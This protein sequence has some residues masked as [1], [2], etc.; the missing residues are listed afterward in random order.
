MVTCKEVSGL[1][2]VNLDSGSSATP[3]PSPATPSPPS[4]V[5]TPSSPGAT[6]SGCRCGVKKAQRIVGGTE[7][8]P[9]NKYPWMAAIMDGTGSSQFCGGTLVA[10]KYVIS[11]A[12]CMFYDQAGTQ[13]R[14]ANDVSVRIGEHDL[15][16]TGETTLPEKTIA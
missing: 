10:S 3:S 16:T 7:V 11:A 9:V 1:S 15:S 8:N 14:P 4:P 6:P 13:P 2:D 5:S 12:H